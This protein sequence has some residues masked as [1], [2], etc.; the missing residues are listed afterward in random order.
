MRV[1]VL[2][3]PYYYSRRMWAVGEELDIDDREE[4]EAKILEAL[5]KLSIVKTKP[6]ARTYETTAVKAEPAEPVAVQLETDTAA[7]DDQPQSERKR[8][9]R[10]RDMKAEQ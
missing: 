10:R 5:G 6:A 3:Q 7:A 4:G 9:Y 8:Y 1:K 2:D